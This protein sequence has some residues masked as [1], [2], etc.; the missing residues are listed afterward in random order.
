[1]RDR[2]RSKPAA[3][4]D[5]TMTDPIEE[6]RTVAAALPPA[7]EAMFRLPLQGRRLC[8]YTVTDAELAA[9]QGAGVT[10]D[11]IFEQTVGV[12]IREGL[13][14]LDRARGG[15][16]LRLSVVDDGHA[17][18]EAAMLGEIRS[19]SGHEPL[20]VVK[21]LLY[22]PEL[23]GRPFSDAL[24]TAMPR[25]VRVER[26]R[27]RALRGFHT[28]CSISVRSERG[29]TARSRRMRSA[30]TCGRPVVADWR[31]APL[32]PELRA[33]LVFLEKLVLRPDELTRADAEAA[34]AAGVSEPA[35]RDAATW[36][37]SSA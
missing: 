8:A 11:E 34:Y 17:P 20:G 14:R 18:A 31:S 24:E 21:T 7:P 16:R 27:A 33:T 15:P 6:L 23:F 22:R 10:Q 19:R 28:R 32:R 36:P 25:A 12:A 5:L 9:L 1:V 4:Y 26:R 3:D 2:D 35:L 37:R 30:R 29:H 13:R